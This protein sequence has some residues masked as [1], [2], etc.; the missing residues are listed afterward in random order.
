LSEKNLWQRMAA[1]KL[2]QRL[3]TDKRKEVRHTITLP[4]RVTGAACGEAQWSEL[5]ETINVSSGGMALRLSKRVMI[6]DILFLE[7]AI[8]ERLQIDTERSKTYKSFARV[9]YIEIR[10][11]QQIVRL[12]FFRRAFRSKTLQVSVRF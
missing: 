3:R 9:R 2:S 6:G 11:R 10:D 4:V 7:V 1:N 8:P 5:G 12:Q